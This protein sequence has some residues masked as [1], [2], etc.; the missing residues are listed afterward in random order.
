MKVSKKHIINELRK[1]GVKATYKNIRWAR[2]KKTKNI[3][4]GIIDYLKR[5]DVYFITLGSFVELVSDYS[6]LRSYIYID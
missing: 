1:L 2:S 5:S 4:G 6:G 3:V